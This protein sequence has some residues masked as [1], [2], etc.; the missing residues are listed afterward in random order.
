ML[1]KLTCALA[2]LF[3]IVLLKWIF[4]KNCPKPQSPFR[5]KKGLIEKVLGI[6]P[7]FQVVVGTPEV[8]FFL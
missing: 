8:A 3:N 4:L 6:F 2:S 7:I 1:W 5:S